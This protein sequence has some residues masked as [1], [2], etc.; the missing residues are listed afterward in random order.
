MGGTSL[1][2]LVTSASVGVLCLF[3]S[4]VCFWLVG[5]RAGGRARYKLVVLDGWVDGWLVG[6]MVGLELRLN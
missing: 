2:G 4:G 6:W 3:R 5:W 1:P